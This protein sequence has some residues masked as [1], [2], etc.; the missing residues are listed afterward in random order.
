MGLV[1]REGKGSK[2][3][4]QEMDGNLTYLDN[5]VGVKDSNK[6]ES[7]AVTTEQILSMNLIPAGTFKDLDA[8]E[9]KALLIKPLENGNVVS[10]AAYLNTSAS[11][12]GANKLLDPIS[13]QNSGGISLNVFIIN[14]FINVI[15]NNKIKGT[16]KYGASG[17]SLN[18]LLNSSTSPNPTEIPFDPTID[19]YLIIAVSLASTLDTITQ[20]SLVF[21]KIN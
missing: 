6:Y 1:T 16:T 13:S 8:V 5:I 14:T 3:T 15:E 9:L 21:K 18:Q 11:M 17:V 7:L 10:L 19:N 2:L 12:S 4:I 20:E